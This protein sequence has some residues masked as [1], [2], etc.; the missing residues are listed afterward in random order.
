MVVA[1]LCFWAGIRDGMTVQFRLLLCPLFG[2]AAT[3][4]GFWTMIISWLLIHGE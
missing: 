4:I 3:Y 2:A 1:A